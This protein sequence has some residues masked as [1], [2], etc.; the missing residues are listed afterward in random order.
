MF[1]PVWNIKYHI[2]WFILLL[3]KDF[4]RALLNI[5]PSERPTASEALKHRWIVGDVAK[6]VDLLEDFIDNFNARK[7]F[8]KAVEVVQAANRLRSTQRFSSDFEEESNKSESIE[9]SEPKKRELHAV[10]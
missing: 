2:N 9:P 6:D 7:T 10:I 5:N 1:K 4:I 3:A 8:K